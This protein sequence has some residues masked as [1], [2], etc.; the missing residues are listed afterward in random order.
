MAK[1]S[2][3]DLENRLYFSEKLNYL[4][5]QKRVR[6]IDLHNELGIPKSTL[7]GYVKGRSLPTAGNLQKLADFF[8]VKKSDLDSRFLSD[9]I[10]PTLAPS[11]TLTKANDKLVQ[12][13]PER[14]E[15]V[16]ELAKKEL[17]EQLKEQASMIEENSNPVELYEV[18]TVTRLAAGYGYSFDDY[19]HDIKYV[20]NEPP[21]HDLASIVDGDSMLPDYEDGD[22]VYLR[23]A[24]FSRYNGQVC[25]IAIDDQTYIKK[26]YTEPKGL[27]LVSINKDYPDRFVGFPPDEGTHIKIFL[28][29]G[30]DRPVSH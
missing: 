5:S 25:A 24:G 23:D 19:D 7:T 2:P 11:S 12:L 30:S 16:L 3:Q 29:I 20:E 27:R 21:R 10:T 8:N 6:Q 18:T 13:T 14:Q 17:E 9:P 4:M 15:R 28:V 22:I 1:N 26:V